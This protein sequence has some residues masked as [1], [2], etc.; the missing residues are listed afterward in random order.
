MEK[1]AFQT[2]N[3]YIFKAEDDWGCYNE[4]GDFFKGYFD[5]DGYC[6]HSFRCTDGKQ[7]GLQEHRMKW[8]YFNGKIPEGMVIDHKIPISEGG[9]NKLSNLRVVTPKENCNNPL[10]KKNLSKALKGKYTGEKH[11]LKGKHHTEETK[12]KMSEWRSKNQFGDK[13]PMYGKKLTDEH[14]LILSKS[15]SKRVVQITD[16]GDKIEYKSVT[17]AAKKNNLNISSI[18]KACKGLYM[19]SHKY[20]NSEWDYLIEKKTIK[21]ESF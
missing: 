11:W 13:N 18:A 8:E 7:H 12:K 17:E 19:G 20:K 21:Y 15:R 3:K 9:T 10:T 5:K 4:K 2:I 6:R 14:K 16:N 1:K